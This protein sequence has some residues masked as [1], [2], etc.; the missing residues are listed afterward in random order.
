M[1]YDEFQD[2]LLRL[3]YAGDYQTAV[4]L[5]EQLGKNYPDEPI[6]DLLHICLL[7]VSRNPGRAIQVFQSAVDK[8]RWYATAGLRGDADLAALQGNP[9]FERLV[10]ICADRHA[11]A[12]RASKP[13]L[14]VNPPAPTAPQPYPLLLALH[15]RGG[16]AQKFIQ[17]W[18]SLAD[19]G[20]LVAA[21]QSSQVTGMEAYGWDDT[22]QA[23]AEIQAHY[24]ALARDYPIDPQ[25]VVLG[26]FSQGAGLAIWLSVSRQVAAAG[27]ISIGP[28]LHELPEMAPQLP[29]GPIPDLRGF[30]ISGALEQDSGMFTSFEAL[31]KDRA[32]PYHWHVYPDLAH[33]MPPDFDQRLQT[34]L[35]FIFT[36]SS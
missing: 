31:L 2:Q 23:I 9:D 12:Q 25:R 33:Q 18:K 19:Q 29:S 24:A 16:S 11:Q 36:K 32:V 8:G 34:A 17:D 3:Y 30:I 15:W 26:G 27:F 28:Y 14:L 5:I 22:P 20:W 6:L 35:D 21:P 1:T 7:S 13:A 10:A 4:D